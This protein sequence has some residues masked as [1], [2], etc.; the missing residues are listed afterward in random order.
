MAAAL[1]GLGVSALLGAGGSYLSASSANKTLKQQ[2]KEGEKAAAQANYYNGL[3]LM[4]FQAN[5]AQKSASERA[6]LGLDL[7][8]GKP[9]TYEMNYEDYYANMQQNQNAQN[10][11]QY[12][13]MQLLPGGNG[14][15]AGNYDI[16][17]KTATDLI[18]LRSSIPSEGF[19]ANQV[20]SVG[21]LDSKL[22]SVGI[23]GGVSGFDPEAVQQYIK[24]PSAGLQGKAK[25]V[26]KGGYAAQTANWTLPDVIDPVKFN[27]LYETSRQYREV[28]YL[29]AQSD[30]ILRQQGPLWESMKQSVLGPIYQGAASLQRQAAEEIRKQVARGGSARITGLKEAERF[31]QMDAINAN[32]TN[33]LW[34]ANLALNQWGIDNSRRQLLFNQQWSAGIPGIRDDFNNAMTNLSQFFGGTLVPT[35]MQNAYASYQATKTRTTDLMGMLGGALV[36]GAGILGSGAP[37]LGG[38]TKP[39]SATQLLGSG[40]IMDP[41]ARQNALITQDALT[42]PAWNDT[43]S[44]VG[45]RGIPYR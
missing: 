27:S 2:Q 32:R 36:M 26:S 10:Q 19:F 29:T 21:A 35:S 1:V 4:D 14:S 39:V 5:R 16:Y 28:S 20:S 45:G 24:N 3:G 40:N 31:R 23:A 41:L 11:N 15:L 30:Q 17:D 33:S 12:S 42:P 9:G 25:E 13:Q 6:R 37:L 22:K 44:Y 38:G 34:N 7:D 43:G 8:L 18:R